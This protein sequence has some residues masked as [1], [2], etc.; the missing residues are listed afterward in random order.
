MQVFQTCVEV[1]EGERK[2]LSGGE[3]SISDLVSTHSR[4]TDLRAQPSNKAE[5]HHLFT[6]VSDQG[7]L[8]VF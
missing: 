7:A 5:N 8:W 1:P 3:P 4:H 6:Q 2:G